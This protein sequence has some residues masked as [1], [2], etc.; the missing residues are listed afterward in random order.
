VI[1]PLGPANPASY[2]FTS[3]DA[4]GRPARWDPCQAI[5]WGFNPDKAPSAALELAQA[6]IGRLAAASG[7]AFSYAGTT[8]YRPLKQPEGAMPAGFDAVIAFGTVDEYADFTGGTFGIGGF[9]SSIGAEGSRIVRGGVVLNAPA[10][11]GIPDGFGRG[12]RRGGALLHELGHMVG[13]DHVSDPAQM[14]NPALTTGAPA[15]YAE[16]DRTGLSKVGAA[17]GCFVVPAAPRF[18]PPIEIPPTPPLPGEV[19]TPPA[20]PLAPIA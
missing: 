11:A 2:R 9:T 20:V 7:L 13:L 1:P 6:A 16:G 15:D 10:V 12:Q 4:L 5:R 17:A 8:S 19:P 14:M 3:V 18:L